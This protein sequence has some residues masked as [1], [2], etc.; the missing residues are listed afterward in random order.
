MEIDPTVIA[1]ATE[2]MGFPKCSMAPPPQKQ[3]SA[4]APEEAVWAGEGGILGRLK[5]FCDDGASFVRKKL[6]QIHEA[7]VFPT[8]QNLPPPGGKF[9]TS[10]APAWT[11]VHST[12]A[13]SLSPPPFSTSAHQT[14]FTPTDPGQSVTSPP[15]S[16]DLYDLVFIDAYDGNDEVPTELWEEGGPFLRHLADVLNPIHGTVLVPHQPETL[17]PLNHK[18]LKP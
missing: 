11:P 10:A 8:T 3:R 16:P 2:G 9:A 5:L 15:G 6:L 13:T 4:P 12:S 17:K 18:T 7:K 1:A 14:P